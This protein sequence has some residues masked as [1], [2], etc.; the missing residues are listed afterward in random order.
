MSRAES[1]R[2]I[3]GLIHPSSAFLDTDAQKDIG[4]LLGY[5]DQKIKLGMGDGRRRE[6]AN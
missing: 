6:A 3:L 1:L 2:Y 4:K 5:S